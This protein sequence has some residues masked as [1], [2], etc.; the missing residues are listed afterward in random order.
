MSKKRDEN[1]K[2]I[3]DHYGVDYSDLGLITYSYALRHI[4]KYVYYNDMD[5]QF[6]FNFSIN[7]NDKMLSR[8]KRIDGKSKR[9]RTI[10]LSEFTRCG[11][12]TLHRGAM[13]GYN[14]NT[15]SDNKHMA[16]EYRLN[17]S[18]YSYYNTLTNK[19]KELFTG[20][21]DKFAIVDEETLKQI[22]INAAEMMKKTRDEMEFE[23]I[24]TL[25]NTLIVIPKDKT[26][27]YY[28]LVDAPK[29]AWYNHDAPDTTIS[30][31]TGRIFHPMASLGKQY[32]QY[33]TLKVNGRKFPLKC[34][35][36]KSS[37]PLLLTSIIDDEQ[38]KNIV[39]NDDIYDWLV[40]KVRDTQYVSKN[41]GRVRTL[42]EVINLEAFLHKKMHRGKYKSPL[43][44]DG[45]KVQFMRFVGSNRRLPIIDSILEQ[46]LPEFYAKVQKLKKELNEANFVKDKQGEY[47]RKELIIKKKDGSEYKKYVKVYKDRCDKIFLTTLLQQIE[48]DIF[49]S[50]W[51]E[52]SD[53][54]I[55]LHD[56][57]YF[58]FDHTNKRIKNIEPKIIKSLEA[59]FAEYGI[60]GYQLVCDIEAGKY[61]HRALPNLM[62]ACGDIC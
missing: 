1:I 17:K 52:Y 26:K 22:N 45:M 12:I 55:P 44:R 31:K 48:S 27:L 39:I 60:T 9:Y 15:Y 34:V 24:D 53:M 20:V 33:M 62:A 43:T 59:K 61:D 58:P 11:M 29:I 36:L 35:D 13:W 18:V 49:I 8:E 5:S 56:C 47:A 28:N 32:R 16:E 38:Y 42:E 51:E 19:T 40:S 23:L 46:H 6:Y 37:Q 30:A 50:T 54:T 41:N 4:F 57:L 7:K 21:T 2:Q 3:L 10:I 25:N 14:I